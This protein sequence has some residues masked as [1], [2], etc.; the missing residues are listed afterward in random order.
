MFGTCVGQQPISHNAH[1]CQQQRFISSGFP[2]KRY[3][4]SI[5]IARDWIFAWSQETI[6]LFIAHSI[7]HTLRKLWHLAAFWRS[8]RIRNVPRTIKH[9]RPWPISL[10]WRPAIKRSEFLWNFLRKND[11]WMSYW[12]AFVSAMVE[13]HFLASKVSR[14]SLTSDTEKANVNETYLT[15]I[16]HQAAPRFIHKFFRKVEKLQISLLGCCAQLRVIIANQS[17]GCA[18][19]FGPKVSIWHF[20]FFLFSLSLRLWEN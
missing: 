18:K 2:L 6:N 10:G 17:A 8:F 15:S 9:Q 20:S 12:H 3:K 7:K 16:C 14:I 13:K 5:I 1:C 11:L 4:Q 19:T